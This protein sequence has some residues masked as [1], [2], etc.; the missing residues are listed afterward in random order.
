MPLPRRTKLAYGVAD[1]GGTL[2]FV[3][4]NTWLLYFLVNVAG[5]SPVLAGAVFVAGRVFDALTD[6]VMGVLS[7]RFKPRW[8]RL[9]FIR[10]GALPLGAAFALLWVVPPGSPLAVF[11]WALA[12]F[13]LFSLAYT[14]VQVPY[15]ALTPELAPDYDGRTQLTSY[16]VAFS[17]L[18]SMLAVAAPPLI[19]ALFSPGALAES[20]PAGWVAM[21]LLFGG[22]S[23]ASYLVMAWSV[24]E[25]PRAAQATAPLLS[26]YRSAFGVHGFPAVF[27]LFTLVTVGI[28]VVNS[29]LP[30]Y[31]ESALGFGPSEQSLA[32]GLL[33]G[34]AVLAFPLWTALAA[35]SG[36]R[37]ALAWGLGLLAS[38]LLLIA[39]GPR[40]LFF[41]VVAL[42]GVGL[43]AVM[44]FPWAML[45]DVVEFDELASGRRREGLLY[46]LFTFGQK[47]AGSAGVFA[48]A[49]V[50]A[51]F[52]YRPGVAEQADGT[53]RSLAWMVGPVA[54]AIFALA[55]VLALRFPIG[56]AEHAAAREK[57]AALSPA[58][59]GAPRSSARPDAG[60]PLP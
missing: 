49:L 40:S 26:E 34:V 6:P 24:R 10:W 4:L 9:P 16:R 18:A 19:V 39:L 27:G 33:F 57:L 30:F 3:A 20:A 14:V 22:L 11:C 45:P 54:A 23:A 50:V 55:L 12:A 25:P 48:G 36:K 53:V 51:L 31:L 2:P 17:V 60:N 46:A 1:V 52:G 5:L 56:R 21:G 43:S 38:G 7:D 59:P 13:I 41:G 35:R 42:C 44:M 47:V 29:V 8:G 58:A 37:A 15:M 32:L 28:M